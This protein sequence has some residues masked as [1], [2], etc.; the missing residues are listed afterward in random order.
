MSKEYDAGHAKH[1]PGI[2][3][4]VIESLRSADV[5]PDFVRID[6]D[7]GLVQKLKRPLP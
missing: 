5:M 2:Q 1:S 4:I 3:S 6:F 7:L